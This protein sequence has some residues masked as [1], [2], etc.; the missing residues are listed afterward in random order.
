MEEMRKQWEAAQREREAQLT[1]EFKASRA[2]HQQQLED[3]IR[4]HEAASHANNEAVETSMQKILEDS[5]KRFEQELA[6]REEEFSKKKKKSSEDAR[7]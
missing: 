4:S 5:C 6:R 1:K 2:E 7:M 3:H